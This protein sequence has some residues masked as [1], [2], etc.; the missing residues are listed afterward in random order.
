M[1]PGGESLAQVGD[2]MEVR[3][4]QLR[5]VLKYSNIKNRNAEDY[6]FSNTW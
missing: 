3:I 4:A 5:D 2:C 6:F 1:A